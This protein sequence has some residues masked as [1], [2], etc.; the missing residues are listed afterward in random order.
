MNIPFIPGHKNI[1]EG[2]LNRFIEFFSDADVLIFDAQFTIDESIEK[3][4]WGHSTSLQ[5][6]DFAAQAN[7]KHILFY[8]HDPLYSDQKLMTILKD[9][10]A[11]KNK[12]YKNKDIKISIARE[13]I[14]ITL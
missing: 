5:G 9:A 2:K 3:E 13:R 6:V 1:S 8:H 4:N 10:I 14:E 7:I 12:H 11:H